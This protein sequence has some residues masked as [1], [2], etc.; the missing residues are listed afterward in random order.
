MVQLSAAMAVGNHDDKAAPRSADA[1]LAPLPKRLRIRRDVFKPEENRVFAANPDATDSCY[2]TPL[3]PCASAPRPRGG[4]SQ[5]RPSHQ[6]RQRRL[7]R[8][9]G[10]TSQCD[11]PLHN[12][13]PLNTWAT[14]VG[15]MPLIHVAAHVLDGVPRVSW[16][17]RLAKPMHKFQREGI[18]ALSSAQA[19]DAP[20]EFAVRG[21]TACHHRVL[22][23][24]PQFM[25]CPRWRNP[26]G[27]L[28]AV[29][30]G[31]QRELTPRRVDER[32]RPPAHR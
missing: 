24:A 30:V 12:L 32:I 17:R 26:P 14:V 28:A 15:E 25:R 9:K 21:L 27:L 20:A 16:P 31:Q 7:N 4:N 13:D 6:V 10:L 1:H 3:V 23:V 29:P 18:E 2:N 19:A 22:V 11:M 8:Q 5:G